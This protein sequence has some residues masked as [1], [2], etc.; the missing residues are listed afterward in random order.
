MKQW[1]T[2]LQFTQSGAANTFNVF[3]NKQGV[4]SRVIESRESL[5]SAYLIQIQGQQDREKILAWAQ[6]FQANPRADKFS[7]ATW[8]AGEVYKGIKLP[9]PNFQLRQVIDKP[10]T[11]LIFVLCVVVFATSQI[12]FLDFWFQ[13]LHIQPFSNLVENQQWWRLLGPNFL[14]FSFVHV[15]FNLLWW[16]LLGGKLE[17]TFGTLGLLLIFIAASLSAN[18]G[19]LFFSGPNFGGMSG[20]VYALFGFI[21]WIGWLRPAWGIAMPKAYIGFLLF[22][23]ALGYLNVLPVNMANEAHLFGLIAGCV[24]AAL[25]HIGSK[26]GAS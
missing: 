25:V 19:Q 11:S 5:A 1:E 15:A 24:M 7:Q 2:V 16:W 12:G 14:H 26:K 21:W 20:V 8:E 4:V 13:N 10:F 23:I 17:Q 22:W 18:L 9:K 6:E 3:L